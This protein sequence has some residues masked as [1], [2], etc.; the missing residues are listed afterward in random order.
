MTLKTRE[1]N[2]QKRSVLADNLPLSTPY[3]VQI[4]PVYGCNFKCSYCLH[5]LKNSERRFV[6]E[7]NVMDFDV[8]K[9]SIDDL[10]EF[11]QKVKM[12]RFAATGEPLLHPN[13][14]KMISY[15]KEM[16]I[17]ES[18]DVVSNGALLTEGLSDK[19]VLAGLNWLRISIQGVSSQRYKDISKVDIDVEKLVSQIRYFYEN[20]KETQVYI[21]II[22]IDLTQAEKNKFFKLFEPIADKIAIE[23]LVPAIEKIDY[24]S[25]SNKAMV[26]SQNGNLIMNAE[27]CPQPFYMMQIN[28]DGNVVPCCAMET[29]YISGNVIREPLV[30]I[31]NG[32]QL[33]E[34]QMLQ[35]K[36]QKHENSVCLGC[37]TYKFNMFKEDILD[38]KVEELITKIGDV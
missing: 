25:I 26:N 14:S 3:M 19:L 8:Y 38:D 20:K 5:S 37:E 12:L 21:K 1:Q 16:D 18:I 9:K 6:A 24:T 33:K 30:E 34:F 29:P 23:Y 7:K 32:S 13:L 35:L 11:P 2:I 31:W 28:P 27:V 36:K 17:A 22:D 10:K 15:A 4:F